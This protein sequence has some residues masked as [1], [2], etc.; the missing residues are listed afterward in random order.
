MQTL[1]NVCSVDD[2][3]SLLPD[4]LPATTPW[5]HRSCPTPECRLA[6]SASILHESLRC[7]YGLKCVTHVS[8]GFNHPSTLR[9]STEISD[10]HDGPTLG[11][12]F[13]FADPCHSFIFSIHC[14]ALC[15]L[16]VCSKELWIS[17][18]LA[19]NVVPEVTLRAS[20]SISMLPFGKGVS[21]CISPGWWSGATSFTLNGLNFAGQWMDIPLLPA[22]VSVVSVSHDPSNKG[23]LWMASN[24][25]DAA[26][27]F[28]AIKAGCSTEEMDENVSIVNY[29]FSLSMF[30]CLK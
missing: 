28:A 10:D 25:N 9:N 23:R 29:P 20:T 6:D 18:S 13:S 11:D 19:G 15:S 8:S 17:A 26:G 3:E 16:S 21:V 14:P 5:V 4:G 30:Y 1:E 27:V 24:S 12:F 2:K 22:T 7:Y